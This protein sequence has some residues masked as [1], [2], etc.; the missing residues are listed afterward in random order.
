[1]HA[2][3]AL[4]QLAALARGQQL[5]ACVAVLDALVA[6]PLLV[7]VLVLVRR[8]VAP[9]VVG[10]LQVYPEFQEPARRKRIPISSSPEPASQSV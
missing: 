6:R 3:G 8:R 4:E 5:L 7:L 1:M 10:L 9:V 2:H